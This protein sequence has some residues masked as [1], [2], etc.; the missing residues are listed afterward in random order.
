MP[1]PKK[2]P[3]KAQAQATKNN[4]KKPTPTTRTPPHKPGTAQ[5]AKEPP[6]QKRTA[7][8]LAKTRSKPQVTNGGNLI[9]NPSGQEPHTEPAPSGRKKRE[10][11]LTCGAHGKHRGEPCRHPAGFRTD[12]PGSGRCY[13]HGGRTPAPT[14][15]Y[16]SV[17]RPRVRELLEQF[18]SDPDPLNLLPEAQLLRALM[19]D[20]INRFEEQDRMLTRWNLSFEKPFQSDWADWWRTMRADALEREDDLSEELLE[21][22][23]DP[24]NYLPSKPLRMADITDAAR[25]IKEVGAMVDRIRKGQQESTFSMDVINRLWVLMGG[26]LTDA[27]MEV[28]E[29]DDIRSALLTAVESRWGTISLAELASRRAEAGAEA[30]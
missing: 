27:A 6:S 3:A 2:K 25:L 26:H 4:T 10:P 8:Y 20:Y 18:E 28:I 15:R 19:L 14:G 5:P 13:L 1:T 23:P 29:N 7:E 22:M 30:G 21:R 11:G 9:Q 17:E 12:H 24:M 16:S